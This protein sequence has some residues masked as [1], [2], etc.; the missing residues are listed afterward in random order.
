MMAIASP[1]SVVRLPLA[2]LFLPLF[3]ASPSLSQVPGVRMVAFV[4]PP[5]TANNF[6]GLE[7]GSPVCDRRGGNNSSA[8]QRCV[9][10]TVRDYSTVT[11]VTMNPTGTEPV[12]QDAT[13]WG[14]G[15]LEVIARNAARQ[16]GEWRAEA[17][18]KPPFWSQNLRFS[19]ATSMYGDRIAVGSWKGDGALSG[20]QM[21]PTG[22]EPL[23]T[24]PGVGQSGCVWILA[25]SPAT[26]AWVFDAYIKPPLPRAN[27]QFGS[28]VSLWGDTLLVGCRNHAGSVPGIQMRPGGNETALSDTGAPNAGAVYVYERN[29]T[30]GAWELVAFVKPPVVTANE[31]FGTYLSLSGD[32]ALIHAKDSTTT[33]GILM[34]P[35]GNE[36]RFSAARGTQTGAFW[37]LN[38]NSASGTLSWS[39]E[40]FLKVPRVSTTAVLGAS[41]FG[42]R[43]VIGA[44]NDDG[45]IPGVVSNPQGSEPALLDTG[46]INSGAVWVAER[47]LSTGVWSWT[48]F[49]KPPFCRPGSQFGGS[50][51]LNGD[52]FI[53]GARFD[54]SAGTGVVDY[55]LGNESALQSNATQALAP[56]SAYVYELV[57]ESWV[58]L[59][60]LKPP[61][62]NGLQETLRFGSVAITD[63]TA[64]VGAENHPS[65]FAG[66]VQN[67]TGN[68]PSLVSPSATRVGGSY[69]YDLPPLI[70]T[71]T[72]STG[73]GTTGLPGTSSSAGTTISS[74][75]VLDSPAASDAAEGTADSFPVI[76]VIIAGAGA[77]A[78]LVILGVVLILRRR[79]RDTD[80]P[81]SGSAE[82]EELHSTYMGFSA[83]TEVPSPSDAGGAKEALEYQKCVKFRLRQ[84]LSDPFLPLRYSISLLTPRQSDPRRETRQGA[85]CRSVWDGLSRHAGWNARCRQANRRAKRRRVCE[86]TRGHVPRSF[87][88]RG[89]IS[90]RRA[91]EGPGNHRIGYGVMHRRRAFRAYRVRRLVYQSGRTSS[92]LSAHVPGT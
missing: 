61:H 44:L 39:Y 59:A 29:A 32:R 31:E 91:F 92:M 85:R 83:V 67:P 46:A 28:S 60:Y 20:I 34:N 38:R 26:G 33:P 35:Q 4:K 7:F 18:V 9:L 79:K 36:A 37:V 90:R 22:S 72:G 1:R 51:S 49:I 41:F 73:D 86:G 8:T 45:S 27:Y 3:L 11:G 25:R 52:R 65:T 10:T 81:D 69:V 70:S 43:A 89:P 2:L 13:Q 76:W 12:F 53:V 5:G 15:A 77:C 56:G 47:D 19:S 78:V 54:W 50:F 21:N 74:T 40:A 75:G 88:V 80:L 16:G 57:G 23:L 62:V 42:N 48:A 55:P 82:Q 24:D 71:T 87:T 6:T 66:I 14:V 68:E 64:V 63:A 30:L 84:S 17:W 58:A